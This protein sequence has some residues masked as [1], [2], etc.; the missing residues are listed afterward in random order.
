MKL[1]ES[2]HRGSVI[3]SM[4]LIAGSC[5]GAGMLGLPVS[6]A[7]AGFQPSVAMFLLSW[8]FMMSTGLLMLEVNL[9]FKEDVNLVTMA[10]RTLGKV[11]QGLAW[12]LF[13]FL[14][15]SIM[16][17]YSAGS[18]ELIADFLDDALSISIPRW[19]GSIVFVGAFGVIIYY[20]TFAVDRLNRILMGGLILTYLFLFFNGSEH[21]QKKFLEHID[22]G[23]SVWAIPVMLIS[24]GYHNLVPSLSTYMDYNPKKMRVAIIGGSAIPLLSY[25]AWEWLILGMIPYEK[26]VGA[27]DQGN[28]VTHTLK[29][30]A[31]KA[32]IVE[33]AQYFAFFAIVTSF[34]GVALSFVDFLADGFGIEK[35]RSGKVTVC[36]MVLLPPLFFALLYPTLFVVALK[37]AGGF[38]AN[39]LFGV[40][41]A[42][43]VWCGRYRKKL[44][45]TC[46]VPGGKFVLTVIIAFAV[47]VFGIQLINAVYY[48]K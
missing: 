32:P 36:C 6:T 34:I 21:I 7:M 27:L 45:E 42:L 3:G 28:M 25:L 46:Q 14:F 16:V 4:L 41:P 8:L 5:I 15:Y 39:I 23:E 44:W 24:F 37:Y 20:G 47:A 9:F 2:Q 38:G 48:H 33:I 11:G 22:W 31:G 26:F 35:T 40:L 12:F 13:L 1:G 19:A 29:E 17:A 18:G 43:M 30:V 10:G